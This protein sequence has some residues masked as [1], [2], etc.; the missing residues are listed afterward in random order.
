MRKKQVVLL[1]MTASLLMAGC[2]T[3][4]GAAAQTETAAQ[5]ENTAETENAGETVSN[6]EEGQKKAAT[7][8]TEISGRVIS[9]SATELVHQTGGR[10][11]HSGEERPSDGKPEGGKPQ[12]NRSE[13]KGSGAGDGKQPS[14]G[15]KKSDEPSSTDEEASAERPSAGEE[16]P[17]E[18]PQERGSSEVQITLSE[19]TAY[20]DSDGNAAA[21]SDI[22]EGTFVTVQ[23]DSSQRAVM[24]TIGR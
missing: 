18:R 16:V 13:P 20:Q 14:A 17:G 22:E 6:T 19:E 11:G 15:E 8:E 10:D 21:F 3:Q 7:E 23:T 2:G 4:N 1:A 12:E 9:L 24:V 5:T